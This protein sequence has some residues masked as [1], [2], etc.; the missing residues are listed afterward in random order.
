MRRCKGAARTLR[1]RCLVKFNKAVVK[2]QSTSAFPQEAW[3]AQAYGTP[4][5]QMARHR[6][7]AVKATGLP[8][9]SCPITAIAL[10]LG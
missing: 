6:A 10:V 7:S 3:G 2:L 9:G 8:K 1:I 4:P 5:T